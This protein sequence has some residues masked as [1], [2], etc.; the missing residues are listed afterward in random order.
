MIG[1]ADQFL[2]TSRVL[3][4]YGV[5]MRTLRRWLANPALSFPKPV[6]INRRLYF[7][8]MDLEAWDSKNG[9]EFTVESEKALGLEITSSVITTYEDFV[10]AM[11][12]RREGLGLSC[13]ET[14]FLAGMQEGYTNKLENYGKGYARGLGPESFPLWLRAL[15]MGI[16]FVDLPR[17]TR[18]KHKEVSNAL[19]CCDQ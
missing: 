5:S 12:A 15:R 7:R 14:D 10:A 13:T 6:R 11:R 16:V 4:R 19:S 8:Q 9:A 18:R 1:M 2:D 3:E 17:R